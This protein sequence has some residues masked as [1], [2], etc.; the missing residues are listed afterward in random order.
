MKAMNRLGYIARVLL[1]LVGASAGF[2][3]VAFASIGSKEI[4][5]LFLVTMMI[6]VSMIV[7]EYMTGRMK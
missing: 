4:A 5:L 7:Y 1:I 3:V 2:A 6:P